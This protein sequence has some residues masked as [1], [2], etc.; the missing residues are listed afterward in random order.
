MTSRFTTDMLPITGP[1]TR[2]YPV[3]GAKSNGFTPQ[4]GIRSATW[5]R[6]KKPYDI[7]LQYDS[8]YARVAWSSCSAS[9]Y[10]EYGDTTAYQKVNGADWNDP[11][12]ASM[13]NKAYAKYLS[14]LKGDAAE[15]GAGIA[16]FR[17]TAEMVSNRSFQLFRVFRAISRGRFGEANSLL[18]IPSG[19]R[20]KARGFGGSVLEYS[21]GWAPTVGDIHNGLKVLTNGVPSSF[22]RASV[23]SVV[24]PYG[25]AGGVDGYGDAYSSAITGGYVKVSVG[26]MISLSNPNLWLLNQLGVINPAAIFWELV[27]FSFLVDYVVNIGDVV[28]SWSDTMGIDEVKP[29]RSFSLELGSQDYRQYGVSDFGSPCYSAPGHR[30]WINWSGIARRKR[31]DLGLPGPTLQLTAPRV[32]LTRAATSISLLLQLLKG[33]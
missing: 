31:R 15:L 4:I 9:S 21:F 17:K 13:Y 33:R 2:T 24:S 25:V 11:L 32:S 5:Y 19:F 10:K 27:P 30:G 23:A 16:E 12:V 28:S 8:L 29:Y 14:K 1:F 22:I 3:H 7:P 18:N 20:P 26:S 6:Q